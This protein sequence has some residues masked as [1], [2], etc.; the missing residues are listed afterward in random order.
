MW[1]PSPGPFGAK[2]DMASLAMSTIPPVQE[3]HGVPT[4]GHLIPWHQGTLSGV[5]DGEEINTE[6]L[7][8]IKA[9]R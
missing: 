1:S 3:S 7:F 6:R 5:Y 9:E 2:V 4:C 8:K